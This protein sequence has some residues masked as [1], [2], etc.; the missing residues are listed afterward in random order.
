MSNAVFAG[1]DGTLLNITLNVSSELA[2]GNYKIQLQNIELSDKSSIAHNT[3]EVASTV[4]VKII[5]PGDTD[6]NGKVTVNDAVMTIN[7]IL[8]VENENFVAAA[9][10]LDGNGT[11][12]VNDVVIMINNYILGGNQQNSLDLSFMNYV[13]ED[14]DYLYADDIEMTAG[15]EKEIEVF[16]NTS[17]TDIQGLQC[18]IYLP[19]G[20]EFVPEI[21]G[22]EIYYADKGDR[23]AKSH[24]VASSLQADGSVRV[25]ETSTSGS[26]FK[27]NE[28]AV[29]TFRIKAKDDITP[30]KKEIKLANM[31]LSYGGE[32]INPEDRTILLTISGTTS[33]KGIGSDTLG[34]IIVNDAIEGETISVYSVNG[35]LLNKVTAN[36]TQTAIG[37]AEHGTY[38]V[39]VGKLTTKLS[40]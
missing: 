7:H 21:D 5:V 16:M 28:E 2:E 26:K 6:G 24:S 22:E 14:A 17:R 20:M 34:N 13:T 1:N 18:D 37:I 32:P 23:A 30:G 35:I 3:M 33:V 38:I 39:K 9:A 19:E 31:E 15:E 4:T 36:G 8:G 27:E 40:L 11:I 12:T 25:V 10:D 29:F